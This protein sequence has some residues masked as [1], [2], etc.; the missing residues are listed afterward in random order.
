LNEVVRGMQGMLERLMGENLT[1][2]FGLNPAPCL[3]M[4]DAGQLEQVVM[5]LAVNARDACRGGGRVTIETELAAV[6]GRSHPLREGNGREVLLRV[7]DT[8]HGMD[9]ATQ[10]RIFEP[11]FTTKAPGEGT[12]LGLSMVYGIVTQSGGNISVQSLPG[13]GCVFELRFAAVAEPTDLTP[14]NP[15]A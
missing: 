8:G 6:G 1:L 9:A 3:L 11:F 5:N 14:T 2:A 15:Y 7:R 12:G 13:L 10:A 4:A